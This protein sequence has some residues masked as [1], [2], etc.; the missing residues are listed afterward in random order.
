MLIMPDENKQ[1][2]AR[3]TAEQI[4]NLYLE[5]GGDIFSIPFRHKIRSVGGILDEK[6]PSENFERILNTYFGDASLADL[7]K[8]CLITSYDIKRR[9]GHFFRQHR[10]RTEEGYN[11]YVRD[12]ARS[13]AAV[14]TYFEA[15]MI[16]S[17]SGVKYPLID[18]G[19]F[20]NN[21]TWCAYADSSIHLSKEGES[22]EP[23]ETVICSIGTGYVREA[24]NYDKAKDWGMAEWIKPLIDIMMSGVADT[25]HFQLQS[26]FEAAGAGDQYFRFNASLPIDVNSAMDDASTDNMNSLKQLGTETAQNM[27]DQ[28]DALVDLIIA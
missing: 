8:P 4:V 5:N 26:V 2:K 11:F 28:M 22:L 20:V 16:S 10:A 13:T 23:K 27:E 24:Y 17:F 14:P 6:Y 19:V 25:V 18:G 21:P 7:L 9:K 1:G 15:N 12:V 3:Y